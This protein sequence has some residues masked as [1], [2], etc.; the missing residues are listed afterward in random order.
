MTGGKL[1]RQGRFLLYSPGGKDAQVGLF[2]GAE[3]NNAE[4]V[5]VVW[6]EGLAGRG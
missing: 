4:V 2:W 5:G 1:G 6:R 3:V